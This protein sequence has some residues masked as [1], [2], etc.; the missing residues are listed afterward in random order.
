M[1]YILQQS[2]PQRALVNLLRDLRSA[3]GVMKCLGLMFALN[4]CAHFQH[5][6][7]PSVDIRSTYK[8][9]VAENMSD[10]RT[11]GP[12]NVAHFTTLFRQA[13]LAY[14]I[15]WTAASAADLS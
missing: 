2:T 11:G 10:I 12:E 8:R 9:L 13:A 6:S 4:E 15:A 7:C 5:P 3:Q 14:A 1:L